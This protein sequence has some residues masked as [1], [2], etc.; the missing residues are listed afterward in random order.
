MLIIALSP[1]LFIG[2]N[3]NVSEHDR[4]MKHFA[5]YLNEEKNMLLNINIFF[6]PSPQIYTAYMKYM[7]IYRERERAFF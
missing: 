1:D 4:F 6:Y 5:L 7:Y 2:K 3:L